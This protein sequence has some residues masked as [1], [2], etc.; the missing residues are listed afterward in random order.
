MSE[1]SPKINMATLLFIGTTLCLFPLPVKAQISADGTTATTVETADGSNFNIKDGD[2]AGGN[3]FHS[4]GNFSVPDAGSAN[5]LNDLDVQ[6][7]IS[8]VTGGKISDIQGAISAQGRANLFLIN[9]VGI[10]FGPNASLN[11]GGSFLG[12]TAD[13]LLF[14]DRTEFSATNFQK[15][16]L[17]INAPIGLN[18]RDNPG[19]IVNQSKVTDSTESLVGLQV[20]PGNNFT[21]VGGDLNF[22]GGKITA[23]GGK[24]AL[25]SL[26]A[27]GIVGFSDNSNLTF[28]DGITRGDISLTNGAAVDVDDGGGGAISVNAQ[29]LN[30]SGKSRLLIGI[31]KEKGTPEVTAG[32]INIDATGSVLLK[33]EAEITSYVSGEGNGGL[34][35]I[36]ATGSVFVQEGSKI[37]S[38]IFGKGNGG[39]IK[40]NAAENISVDGGKD[41]NSSSITS[42]LEENGQGKAGRVELSGKNLFVTNLGRI[43]TGTSGEGDAGMIAI[44]VNDTV[45]ID[46]NESKESRDGA[47]SLIL[48]EGQGKGNAG[49]INIT[50]KN[51]SIT[52]AGQIFTDQFGEGNAGTIKIQASEG[53]SIAA[54]AVKGDKL[55]SFIG[56]TSTVRDTAKGN[57]GS[58]EIATKNLSITDVAQISANNFGEGDAGV[59]KI[60]A[61]DLSIDG[62]NN[63]QGIYSGITT[64]R[65]GGTQ[66]EGN[67][68]LIDITT[69]NLS[70]TNGGQIGASSYQ[71]GGDGGVVKINAANNIFV[72]GRVT[73]SLENG[74]I[75]SIPTSISSGVGPG[76][77]GNGGVIEITAKNLSITN[78]GAIGTTIK[79]EGNGGRVKINA[80]DRISVDGS[81]DGYSSVIASEIDPEGKGSGGNIEI[82]TRNLSLTNEGQIRTSI[83]AEGSSGGNITLNF[84]DIL[85][86]R[87]NSKI[88][89][90]AKGYGNGG[91][92]NIDAPNGFIVAFPDGDNDILATAQEG[93]GGKITINAQ[94]IYGFD[95]KNIQSI[96][97]TQTLLNNGKND[98]NSTSANPELSGTI[99]LNTQA[100]DPV[101]KT[102]KSSANLVEPDEIVA[103]ACGNDGSR[104][105][106][107][108]FTITGRGGMPTDPTKPLSSSYLSGDF[109]S[110]EAQK[111]R[112]RE[113]EKQRNREN[114][115][116]AISLDENKK[117]FSSDQVIPARG[118]IVNEKGEIILTAYPTPNASQRSPEL[119]ASCYH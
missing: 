116:D 6:N 26:G 50:A 65:S 104:Q 100:L 92:I 19:A 2:R 34:I 7:I 55:G 97:D 60:N 30:L 28:P 61:S 74:K 36:N 46:G 72:D 80:S 110:R 99:N 115:E 21:L 82:T 62:S 10:V 117:T 56:I 75:G 76:I 109:G 53:I 78:G 90:E 96:T 118:M 13:S 48:S 20:K 33:D 67:I 73:D 89:A 85:Y 66:V 58:V 84:S 111:Q 16:L 81:K 52:N 43:G 95:K 54:D 64:L 11:I 41:D 94:R 23:R 57:A 91:N 24:V 83:P 12:S 22:D 113:E 105:L 93:K 47:F 98:I 32:E 35:E 8:R 103:Q 71:Q 39:L 25:G 112:S 86:L 114:E 68:G 59:V 38:Y 51:L 27:A 49:E 69:N 1:T 119:S 31:G 79:G 37:A 18:L 5:F 45:F 15:P 44:N 14:S 9:P 29:N 88:S 63:K 102:T 108:T 87:N 77:K 101:K 107:N 42:R 17:T 4:F 70:I 40:I 106:A 3:L